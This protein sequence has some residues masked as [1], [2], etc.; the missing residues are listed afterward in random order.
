MPD[1]ELEDAR[2]AQIEDIVKRKTGIAAENIV[3]TPLNEGEET[4]AQTED[5]GTEETAA[6]GEIYEEAADEA[7][8][9]EETSG[10]AEADGEIVYEDEVS[11]SEETS[12]DY[13]IETEGIYD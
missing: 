1:S 11:D 12:D 5:A 8:A 7:K 10:E 2:R 6:E 13:V 4:S 3:I 9:A